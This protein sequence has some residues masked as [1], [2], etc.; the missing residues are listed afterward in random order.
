MGYNILCG[1]LDGPVA[2]AHMW[3]CANAADQFLQAW[4]CI[5]TVS[6]VSSLLE[7]HHQLL[8]QIKEVEV[9][10]ELVKQEKIIST[11]VMIH[12]GNMAVYACV[13]CS[14]KSI[15]VIRYLNT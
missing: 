2:Q 4:M 10:T 8:L 6:F 12:G 11:H 1:I 5:M 15:L 3:S 9:S 14:S 13:N 7:K